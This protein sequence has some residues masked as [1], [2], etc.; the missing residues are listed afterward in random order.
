VLKYKHT[1]SP[2]K[3]KKNN[4]ISHYRNI[5]NHKHNEEH[6]KG[7]KFIQSENIK[8]NEWC[9]FISIITINVTGLNS[10]MTTLLLS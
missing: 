2:R 4:Q 10:S 8:Q 1:R 7:R 6:R 3:E 9:Y 5:L